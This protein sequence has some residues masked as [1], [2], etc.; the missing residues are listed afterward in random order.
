[1]CR[2]RMVGQMASLATRVPPTCGRRSTLPASQVR[3]HLAEQ[4]VCPG[5]D[6]SLSRETY[7]AAC[8][9]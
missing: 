1:M 5:S 8:V 9:P 4:R 3:K 7:E 2:P 6:E